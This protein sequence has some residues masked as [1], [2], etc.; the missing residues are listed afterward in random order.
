M[1]VNNLTGQDFFD[2]RSFIGL[3]ISGAAKG[4]GINRNILSSFEREK[5]KLSVNEKRKLVSYYQDRGYDF[6]IAD[7]AVV[8]S[9]ELQQHHID[10]VEQVKGL[11]ESD[12]LPEMV[13]D[14]LLNLADSVNDLVTVSLFELVETVSDV[15]VLGDDY[16]TLD[17]RLVE[18]F[19]ADKSGATKGKVCFFGE[20]GSA[21]SEKLLC[22]LALQYLR[23]LQNQ[24]PNLVSLSLAA[25]KEKTDNRRLLSALASGLDNECLG[26]FEDMTKDL[27]K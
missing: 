27:V 18:H 6:S 19:K 2:A 16:L 5:A 24:H 15:S 4:I 11:A 3:S 26:E 9:E 23:T 22:L 20:S 14:A 8:D 17:N 25:T 21:R 12:E 1:N 10:V 13:G 7:P